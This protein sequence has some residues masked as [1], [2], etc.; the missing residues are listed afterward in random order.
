MGSRRGL[1]L[2]RGLGSQREVDSLRKGLGF[3]GVKGL[4]GLLDGLRGVEAWRG[5]R[6]LELGIWISRGVQIYMGHLNIWRHTNTWGYMDAPSVSTNK[7]VKI[8]GKILQHC[9][10]NSFS[11]KWFGRGI[12]E[13]KGV[14]PRR[15]TG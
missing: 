8:L 2:G 14:C 6:S 1:G 7:Q 12:R 11:F 13:S 3:Q 10:G 4:R 9:C 5:L 15:N